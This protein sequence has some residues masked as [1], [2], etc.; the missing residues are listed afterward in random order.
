MRVQFEHNAQVV[1]YN[2]DITKHII[3][4]RIGILKK[5]YYI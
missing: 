5:L 4:F 2:D 3:I 1:K